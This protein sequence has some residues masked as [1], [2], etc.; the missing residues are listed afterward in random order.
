M[1]NEKADA[2]YTQRELKN[3]KYT[4]VNCKKSYNKYIL[5]YIYLN[6]SNQF[7]KKPSCIYFSD[8]LN[9]KKFG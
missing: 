4:K 3:N 5:T 9:F 2:I 1:K 8:S 6:K 7:F